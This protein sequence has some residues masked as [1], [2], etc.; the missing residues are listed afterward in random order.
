VT[1]GVSAA[2]LQ[3]EV[4]VTVGVSAAPLQAEACKQEAEL[5]D[6]LVDLRPPVSA[7]SSA[8][9]LTHLELECQ[10]CNQIRSVLESVKIKL[11]TTVT[12][13]H[14]CF[15]SHWFTLAHLG[16]NPLTSAHSSSL[17]PV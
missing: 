1:V 16:S 9:V 4:R 7:G 8:A 5:D 17:T 15:C 6:L 11:F 2:P 12:N 3:A 10:S 14:M 13:K